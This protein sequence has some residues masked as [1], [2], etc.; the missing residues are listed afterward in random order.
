MALKKKITKAEFE[1]LSE[2]F[3]T[4][5]KAEGDEYKLDLSDDEDLTPLKNANTRL[6]EEKAEAKRLLKEATEKLE[7]LEEGDNKKKGDVTALE[8]SWKTKLETQANEWK[9]KTDKLQASL[10]KTLVGNVALKLASELSTKAPKLLMPHILSRLQANFDGDEPT[11]R[12]L[13]A[14]GKPSAL[15]IEDLKKEFIDNADF[16][17]IITGSKA[18]GGAGSEKKKIGGA[19]E[20]EKPVDLSR[21]APKELAQRIKDNKATT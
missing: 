10:T 21:L 16:S 4:E 11:T 12:I 6:K 14:A 18:T 3:K 15:T 2:H 17:A 13:D 1:K 7:L 19:D 5:Y 8:N 9:G 20:N